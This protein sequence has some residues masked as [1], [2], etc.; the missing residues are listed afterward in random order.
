MQESL[1]SIQK[2]NPTIYKNDNIIHLKQMGL[3]QE[4]NSSHLQD[5]GENTDSEK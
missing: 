5:K 4:C 2:M 1:Q 3:M